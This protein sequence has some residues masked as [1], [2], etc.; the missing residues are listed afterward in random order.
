MS[1]N[2]RI[3]KAFAEDTSYC[4]AECQRKCCVDPYPIGL[5]PQEAE[6][7]LQHH[8]VP[9]VM[10]DVDGL[11]IYRIYRVS[12]CPYFS[13]DGKCILHVSNSFHK[14]LSCVLYPLIFWQFADNEWLAIIEPCSDGFRWWDGEPL[15][16]AE[17]RK[18]IE[19][20]RKKL[21]YLPTFIGDVADPDFP[22]TG[23]SEKRVRQELQFRDRLLSGY[24]PL[25]ALLNYLEENESL[26][27][28]LKL[29]MLD[30]H[31]LISTEDKIVHSEAY[32]C[33]KLLQGVKNSLVW[34]GFSATYMRFKLVSSVLLRLL[35]VKFRLSVLL[36]RYEDIIT[37][38]IVEPENSTVAWRFINEIIWRLPQTV[39]ASWW[40]DR[41]ETNEWKLVLN[42][43]NSHKILRKLLRRAATPIKMRQKP[44]WIREP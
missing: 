37:A 8:P 35:A 29:K 30:F 16:T 7:L 44:I 36:E 2:V 14:P 22:Y 18:T 11:P 17:L 1:S 40:K 27:S 26:L 6:T 42:R 31:D 5:L 39:S 15:S 23:I 24:S 41:I 43:K 19:K 3:Y 12:K 21:G 4:C 25:S 10:K 20:A 33:Q 28:P 34:L 13:E 9:Q 38:L 32:W